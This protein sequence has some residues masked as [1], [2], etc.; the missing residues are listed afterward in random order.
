MAV[1]QG[2]RAFRERQKGGKTGGPSKLLIQIALAL[3]LV[4]LAPLGLT[5][6][7][8][9]EANREAVVDQ[10]LRTHAAVAKAAASRLSEVFADLETSSKSLM[11]PALSPA[12][13]AQAASG[14]LDRLSSRGAVELVLFDGE[15]RL[16][17]QARVREAPLPELSGV[18]ADRVSA[19][20]MAIWSWEGKTWLRYRASS[21]SGRAEWLLGLPHD[22]A[23]WAGLDALGDSAH[24]LILDE[25][26]ALRWGD[27]E[28]V[29][30]I[31]PEVLSAVGSTNL[32]EGATRL[33][34]KS[35]MPRV[36]AWSSVPGVGWKV[37]ST[38]PAELAARALLVL[39]RR[40]L[41]AGASG[42]GLVL[43]LSAASWQLLVR[44]VRRL[45]ALEWR[46]RGLGEVGPREG[47]LAGLREAISAS[48][49]RKSPE[50]PWI[51][52]FSA[53]TRSSSGWE[54]GAW[55][56]FFGVGIPAFSARWRS[57]RSDWIGMS[58]EE[59]P[60]RASSCGKRSLRRKSITPTWLP[61]STP[62][63]EM[64]RSC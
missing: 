1:G 41:L 32:A 25:K 42:L 13:L 9:A 7:S 48:R 54:Q 27:S 45:L 57:K 17:L 37:I 51:R 61:F 6:W 46:L 36:L 30:A 35:A 34:T 63:W 8:L 28:E 50:R 59:G 58:R 20:P 56:P 24:L 52:F 47:E 3:G 49:R 64:E 2:T 4:G 31:L 22:L 23:N 21:P 10:L 14:A 38:Q 62:R 12:E 15:G 53:G 43:V 39:E 40:A 26:G 33:G 18:S 29:K 19:G 16:R 55:E 44:P 11:D 60:M 5:F